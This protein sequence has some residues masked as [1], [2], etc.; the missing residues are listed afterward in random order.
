MTSA[1]VK[2]RE[3]RLRNGAPGR[4]AMVRSPLPVHL[5]HAE[6]PVEPQRGGAV[7]RFGLEVDMC[8]AAC[9]NAAKTASSSASPMPSR[10]WRGCTAKSLMK[11]RVQQKAVAASCPSASC[12]RKIR[13]GSNSGSAERF[14]HHSSNGPSV[15]SSKQTASSVCSAGAS[16]VS[17]VRSL[18][19]AGRSR[20][21]MSPSS[22]LRSRIAVR[23]G[24]SASPRR[25]GLV[26]RGLCGAAQCQMRRLRTRS[27]PS[28]VS[29]SRFIRLAS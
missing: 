18:K 24:A 21:A 11:L 12:T 19:P 14:G 23:T 8:C 27:R 10:R 15:P 28:P 5:E 29:S 1:A 2:G 16:E 7:G 25:V 4:S 22:S 17:K 6:P 26:G 3:T 9:L 20:A 13:E